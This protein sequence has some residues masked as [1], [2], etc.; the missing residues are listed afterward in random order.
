MAKLEPAELLLMALA[1]H[2]RTIDTL[3]TVEP[4]ALRRAAR[5]EDGTTMTAEEI[6]RLPLVAHLELH[7]AQLER[8]LDS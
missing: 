6:A 1:D 8:A 5:L 7:I 2:R 3:R 4:R